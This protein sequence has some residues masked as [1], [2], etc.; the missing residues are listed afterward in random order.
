M[1]GVGDQLLAGA[2]LALD[3]DVRFAGGDALDQIEQL[4]HL[5]ALA[6][7]VLE[8]V[9]VLQ[10]RLQVLVLVDQGLLFDRLLELVEQTFSVDRLLQEIKRPR[11][12]RL[13]RSWDVPLPGD[14]DDL[15]FGV[16]LLEL[17]NQL[18]AVDVGQHHI[19]DDRVGSPGL[20]QLFS[21]CTD[22]RGSYFITGVLEQ[23]FQPL[24]HR[25]LVIYCKYAPLTFNTHNKEDVVIM[26]N[27]SIH[28]A[29]YRLLS[30]QMAL[31]SNC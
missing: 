9:A 26:R 3:E 1:D 12:H 7:H 20:E 18:D 10:L 23:N 5:L 29:W 19:G 21:A 15:S 16:E 13:D 11:F 24:G 25:R 17:A 8:F 28:F 31:P 2:V 27:M 6:D 14:D 22:E 30:L 4:L